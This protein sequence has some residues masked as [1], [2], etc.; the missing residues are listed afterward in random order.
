MEHAEDAEEHCQRKEPSRQKGV[1]TPAPEWPNN[2]TTPSPQAREKHPSKKHEPRDGH[3]PQDAIDHPQGCE[4]V[5]VPPNASLRCGANSRNRH[6]SGSGSKGFPTRSAELRACA[7]LSAATIAEHRNTLRCIRIRRR[8]ANCSR[9]RRHGLGLPICIRRRLG[10]KAS[11][12]LVK[13]HVWLWLTILLE[14]DYSPS[15]HNPGDSEVIH[16]PYFP[17]SDNRARR[18][19]GHGNRLDCGRSSSR[20]PSCPEVSFSGF[21]Q[22]PAST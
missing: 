2:R 18:V 17:L 3:E 19:G 8:R 16:P 6:W 5:D 14:D 12:G 10:F 9:M 13:S 4:P 1:H 20:P 22:T 21:G 15:N 11:G 7:E